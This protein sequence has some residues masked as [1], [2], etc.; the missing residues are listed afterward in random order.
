MAGSFMFLPLSNYSRAKP[1]QNG[2]QAGNRRDSPVQPN[3]ELD[4]KDHEDEWYD[5]SSTEDEMRPVKKNADDANSHITI[6]PVSA[7][8]E[9]KLLPYT[10]A[11]FG[12][13]LP[14]CGPEVQVAYQR[15][16][17]QLRKRWLLHRG[18]LS[19]V[20]IC[21]AVKNDIDA[22][23]TRFPPFSLRTSRTRKPWRREN[24]FKWEVCWASYFLREA[25]SPDLMTESELMDRKK[26]SPVPFELG[27]NI[28]RSD[29][30]KLWNEWNEKKIA[31]TPPLPDAE[32]GAEVVSPSG[33]V[34]EEF[35]GKAKEV[36]PT[37]SDATI[38]SP[39]PCEA[40]VIHANNDDTDDDAHDWSR[41]GHD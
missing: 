24:V 9:T 35:D 39:V 19:T 1:K 14:P 17:D 33:Q 4:V 40:S 11:L 36:S 6:K 27:F 2:Q 32:E 22:Q 41:A 18:R 28:S 29:I 10:P 23:A 30:V 21:R 31:S 5:C 12:K 26:L 20:D 37:S 25:L 8:E 3:S 13:D 38:V 15:V 16:N 7:V 34:K